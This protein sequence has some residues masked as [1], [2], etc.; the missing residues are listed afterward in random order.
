MNKCVGLL[1]N[2]GGNTL[3]DGLRRI[4]TDLHP[5]ASPRLRVKPVGV[6]LCIES[7]FEPAG[8]S[9]A[10]GLIEQHPERP[11]LKNEEEFVRAR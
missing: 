5:F 10:R 9:V 6:N 4:V 1:I 2:F 8:A 7:P 11:L 3:K